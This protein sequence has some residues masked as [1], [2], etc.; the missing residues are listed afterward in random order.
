MPQTRP[1]HDGKRHC[2]D[3]TAVQA[4]TALDVDI[5]SARMIVKALK[6]KTDRDE[7]I[8]DMRDQHEWLPPR[9]FARPAKE[10]PA[11][12]AGCG[13]REPCRERSIGYNNPKRRRAPA[14]AT[15]AGQTGAAGG[16]PFAGSASCGR[17]LG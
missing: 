7:A 1:G 4:C 12:K 10:A 17:S 15:A 11:M 16:R 5:T 8:T 13:E 2:P 9:A 3:S 14:I 6:R